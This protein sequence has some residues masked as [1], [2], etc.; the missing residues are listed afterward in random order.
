[1]PMAVSPMRLT[2]H[3]G[4]GMIWSTEHQ[5]EKVVSASRK[6]GEMTGSVR[7]EPIE[8]LKAIREAIERTLIRPWVDLPVAKIRHWQLFS[9]QHPIDIYDLADGFVVEADVPGM[10]AEDLSVS[11]SGST[12]QIVGERRAAERPCIHRERTAGKFGRT[13]AIPDTVDVAAIKAKLENGVLVLSMPTIAGT[14]SA[15]VKVVPKP[16]EP[17]SEGEA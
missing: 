16:A 15:S 10:Q 7:W 1:M 4:Q 8:D 17:G 11:V 5:T 14:A 9:V 12:L 13:L 3:S 6:E 2:D